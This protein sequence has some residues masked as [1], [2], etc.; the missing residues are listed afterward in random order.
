M[1]T[2]MRESKQVMGK[3]QMLMYPPMRRRGILLLELLILQHTSES[4]TKSKKSQTP[5]ENLPHH[6]QGQ[7]GDLDLEQQEVDNSRS[8]DPLLGHGQSR[9]AKQR[10][11]S[12]SAVHHYRAHYNYHVLVAHETSNTLSKG[13]ETPAVTTLL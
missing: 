6:Q 12:T 8:Q 13:L 4:N 11:Q 10:R 3:N 5:H 1:W 9:P 2:T 7:L